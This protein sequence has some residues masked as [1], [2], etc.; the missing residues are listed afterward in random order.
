MQ[1]DNTK[2]NHSIH[3]DI[4]VEYSTQTNLI[5]QSSYRYSLQERAEPNL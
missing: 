5:E 4:K 2:F 3:S 1:T